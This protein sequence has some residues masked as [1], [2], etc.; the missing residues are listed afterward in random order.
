MFAVFVITGIS[1]K[2]YKI[3]QTAYRKRA[4][5][6]IFICNLLIINFFNNK[7]SLNKYS[8]LQICRA[9]T[10]L[11]FQKVCQCYVEPK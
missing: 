2:K 1:N 10:P 9:H 6:I 5:N 4:P 3:V 7:K 11:F 8:Y